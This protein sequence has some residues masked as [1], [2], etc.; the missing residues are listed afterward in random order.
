VSEE[1]RGNQYELTT[2]TSVNFWQTLWHHIPK[3]VLSVVAAERIRD[4]TFKTLAVG[5]T[6][7]V[8]IHTFAIKIHI[9]T[10]PAC[11]QVYLCVMC[12]DGVTLMV[13][14]LHWK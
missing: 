10:V 13:T 5:L 14:D 9:F 2:D 1:H 12:T 11:Q 3:I 8:A 7:S 6:V 4:P